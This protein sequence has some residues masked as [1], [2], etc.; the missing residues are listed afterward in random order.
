[1]EVKAHYLDIVQR[2]EGILA[3]CGE[4]IARAA[5]VGDQEVGI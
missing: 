3:G 1:V 2:T 5:G 4:I